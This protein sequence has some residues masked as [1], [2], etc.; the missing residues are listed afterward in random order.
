MTNRS[1][2]PIVKILISA[3]RIIL[4][5]IFIFAS[6]DKVLEPAAFADVIANYRILPEAWVAPIAIFLP[7]LELTSGICLVANR[8]TR[9]S[10]IIVTAL[11]VIFTAAII[12]NIYRGMD[13][14][15]GCFT[16]D[17]SAPAGMWFYLLRDLIFLL[18]GVSALRY[19]HRHETA[20]IAAYKGRG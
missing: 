6:W 13:I 9:G 5:S 3:N 4:G 2:K 7:W 15:C 14:S 20:A 17:Q 12:L 16:L 10:A 1:M 19:A 8:W 11:T 18:M